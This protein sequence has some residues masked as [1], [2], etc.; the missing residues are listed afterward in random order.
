MGGHRASPG[1]A[2]GAGRVIRSDFR[3]SLIYLFALLRARPLAAEQLKFI[4]ESK[5]SARDWS[6]QTYLA[7]KMA[8]FQREIT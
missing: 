1:S 2:A 5:P 3:P 7:V 6:F 4:L 8:H